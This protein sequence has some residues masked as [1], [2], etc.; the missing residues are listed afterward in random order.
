MEKL[1]G[2]CISARRLEDFAMVGVLVI[3]G[4]VVLLVAPCLVAAT[5]DLDEEDAN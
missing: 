4:F 3:V 5:I 2:E 1:S